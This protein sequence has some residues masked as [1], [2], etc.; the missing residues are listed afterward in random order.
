MY[1]VLITIIDKQIY[2]EYQFHGNNGQKVDQNVIHQ[3]YWLYDVLTKIVQHKDFPD[4]VQFW[5]RLGYD[6]FDLYKFGG[7][8]IDLHYPQIWYDNDKTQNVIII[9]DVYILMNFVI[10]DSENSKYVA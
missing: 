1:M 5:W 9:P 2:W 4:R 10:N 7:E 8:R 3:L 6:R